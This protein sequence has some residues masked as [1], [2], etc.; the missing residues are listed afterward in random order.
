M[1][2]SPF[3]RV[4]LYLESISKLLDFVNWKNLKN[5]SEIMRYAQKIRRDYV[6][7]VRDV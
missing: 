3:V 7:N 5:V 2:E 1:D 4:A 6:E